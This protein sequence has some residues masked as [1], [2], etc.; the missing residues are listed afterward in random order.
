ML[1]YSLINIL[2]LLILGC[3]SN[4]DTNT[5]DPIIEPIP[6]ET[7]LPSVYKQLNTQNRIGRRGYYYLP[8]GYNLSAKPLMILFH[9]TNYDGKYMVDLFKWLAEQN[10]FIIIAPDSNHSDPEWLVP[11]QPRIFTSDFNHTENCINEVLSLNKVRVDYIK[12]LAGG[13][14]GGGWFATYFGTNSSM[15][16]SFAV[17]HGGVTI[18]SVGN[19][20]IPGFFSSGENDGVCSPSFVSYYANTLN[21]MGFNC[22]YTT[23]IEDHFI[24]SH[25]KQ[26]LINWWLNGIPY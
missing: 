6:V 15:V 26:E 19:N 16:T 21:T 22:I 3:G 2:F 13:W 18:E 20:T 11:E 9:G 1:K 23:F 14:S 25:E 5:E 10:K 7:P 4:Q 24:G 17:L 8:T 12:I